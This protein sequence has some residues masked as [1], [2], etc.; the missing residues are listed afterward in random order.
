M[1]LEITSEYYFVVERIT[2]AITT[3]NLHC[4]E[5]RNSDFCIATPMFD[6]YQQFYKI[7]EL[8]WIESM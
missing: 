6:I 1:Q 7:L 5:K 2:V 4:S 8:R 3:L